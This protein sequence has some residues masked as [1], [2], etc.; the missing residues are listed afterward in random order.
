MR[1]RPGA[2]PS[3]DTFIVSETVAGVGLDLVYVQ[4]DYANVVASSAT[5]RDE[6]SYLRV[7]ASLP[8]DG[9]FDRHWW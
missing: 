4:I 3:A 9:Q 2:S 7:T 6:L 5:D 8:L 1:Y